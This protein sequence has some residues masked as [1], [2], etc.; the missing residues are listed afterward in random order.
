M[1]ANSRSSLKTYSYSE[2]FLEIR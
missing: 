2:L 1:A